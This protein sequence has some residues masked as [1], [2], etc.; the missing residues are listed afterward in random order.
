M[1]FTEAAR[2]A[3]VIDMISPM[4]RRIALPAVFLDRDG[5]IN[6]LVVV[7]STRE[8][9]GLDSPIRVAEF[10]LIDGVR[11]S[12]IK[13]RQLDVLVFVVSN[14]PGY[15]KG[16]CSLRAIHD[17]S[18]RM[19]QLVAHSDVPIPI[20]EIYY[21]THHPNATKVHLRN[22]NCRKPKPGLFLRAAAEWN[23]DLERSVAVGDRAVDTVAAYRAG[24]G[25]IVQLG[26]PDRPTTLAGAMPTIIK[27]LESVSISVK[28]K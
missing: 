1:P 19:M 10:R 27:I 22:C 25:G 23:I 6:H 15:A 24:V 2:K 26:A 16:K 21:C 13:L 3:G 18:A 8:A 28:G 17:I 9:S 14:Q 20:T 4:Y 7:Q 11:E 5:V 12:L